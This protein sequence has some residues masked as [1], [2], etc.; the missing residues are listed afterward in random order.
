M[1]TL[2]SMLNKTFTAEQRKA[3]RRKAKIKTAAIRLQRLREN[4]QVTQQ[5]LAEAMGTTQAA[6]SKL[7]RRPNVT[8]VNVQRYIEALGGRLEMR[9]VFKE[10]SEEILS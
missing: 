7:E 1:K 2:D 5:A 10:E 6:V 9:A 3:I 4:R 8:I